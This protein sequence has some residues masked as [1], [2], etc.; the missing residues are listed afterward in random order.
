MGVAKTHFST[1]AA[2][3]N[4][5]SIVIQVK[6]DSDSKSAYNN[7]KTEFNYLKF[8]SGDCKTLSECDLIEV[9]GK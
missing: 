4:L 3:H 2:L 5:Y 8:Y 7:D 9:L 1:L 6:L